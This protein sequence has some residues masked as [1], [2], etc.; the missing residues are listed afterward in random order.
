MILITIPLVLINFV[1]GTECKI[2][3]DSVAN[4]FNSVCRGS[5]INIMNIEVIDAMQI[6]A[7]IF[8]IAVVLNII[9]IS[10]LETRMEDCVAELTRNKLSA[11]DY[12]F[13]I[14]GLPSDITVKEIQKYVEDK[15]LF[16]GAPDVTIIKIYLIYNFKEYLKLLQT[17]QKL[18]E[19]TI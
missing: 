17:R 1:M 19:T 5:A 16:S 8:F 11:A 7:V 18:N 3:N 12:S 9:F 6:E 13:I 14:K 10:Y 2:V 4:I 15:M